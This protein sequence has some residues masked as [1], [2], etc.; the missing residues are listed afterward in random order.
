M[1]SKWVVS[2]SNGESWPEDQNVGDVTRSPWLN[3]VEYI[4]NNN[5]EVRHIKL[6]VNGIEYNSPT[7]NAGGRFNNAAN[8][9][10]FWVARRRSL[11]MGTGIACQK[12]DDYI[13]YSYSDGYFRHHFIVD[14]RS[15]NS[16]AEITKLDEG[17]NLSVIH[18]G[19]E[20]W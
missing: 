20:N 4:K 3:L 16:W 11:E 2:L 5:L 19:G 7:Y 12:Q 10:S 13:E 6:I 17:L 8:V 15:N 14:V 9:G 1:R 18:F